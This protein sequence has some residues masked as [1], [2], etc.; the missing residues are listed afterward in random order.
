[1]SSGT[2]ASS[3][4]DAVSPCRS[5]PGTA[6]R[7]RARTTCRAGTSPAEEVSSVSSVKDSTSRAGPGRTPASAA[8]T[9]PARPV[10]VHVAGGQARR[11]PAARSSQ[12]GDLGAGLAEQPLLQHA[13]CALPLGGAPTAPAAG[14]RPCSGCAH[15]GTAWHQ[16]RSPVSLVADGVVAQLHLAVGQ[17]GGDVGWLAA[18]WATRSSCATR[19]QPLPACLAARSAASASRKASWPPP[20]RSAGDSR[21]WRRRRRC[22]RRSGSG[23]AEDVDDA[24]GDLLAASTIEPVD[25]D[26]ELVAAEAG[27]QVVVAD[28][29]VQPAGDLDQQLVTGLVPGDVVDGL[30]AVEVEHQQAALAERRRRPSPGTACARLGSRSGGRC[31][32]CARARARGAGGW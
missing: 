24:L 12:A 17:R 21:R 19:T 32:P 26:G 14:S 1:M 13:G 8:A 16:R 15:T 4:E 2:R 22:R 10:G 11:R 18:A 27:D 23:M 25:Q 3:D 31:R 5:R 6:G 28:D 20:G 29:G 9:S 7:R 30:E